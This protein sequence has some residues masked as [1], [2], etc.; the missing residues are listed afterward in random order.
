M[1]VKR[2]S[3]MVNSLIVVNAVWGSEKVRDLIIWNQVA[4][5]LHVQVVAFGRACP[6]G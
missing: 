3:N 6:F 1:I 4:V 5:V 2:E